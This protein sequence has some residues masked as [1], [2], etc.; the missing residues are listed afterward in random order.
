MNGQ[1]D[2][3]NKGVLFIKK[4]RLNDRQPNLTGKINVN[5]VD[6]YLSAWTNFKKTDGEKYLSLAVTPVNDTQGA[7]IKGKVTDEDAIP[8]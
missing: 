4:D 8:F 5:G 7:G 1:Y 3:T 6:F 2:N